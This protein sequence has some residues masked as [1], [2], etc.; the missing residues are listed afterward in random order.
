MSSEVE[1]R[2]IKPSLAELK[3]LFGAPPVL[4]SESEDHY[5]E[6]MIR[7]MSC[8]SAKDVMEMSLVKGIVDATWEIIRLGRHKTLAIE[9]KF[10]RRVAYQSRRKQQQEELKQIISG[11][12]KAEALNAADLVDF[13]DGTVIDV[14]QFLGRIPNELD[15]AAALQEAIE[16]YEKLAA[17]YDAEMSKRN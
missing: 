15:H 13:I 17:L 16:L 1:G 12:K 8:L 6:I 4:S 11:G 14:D 3:S 9:R 10:R 2:E 5:Y 7:M